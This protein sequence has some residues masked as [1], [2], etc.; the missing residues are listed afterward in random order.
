MPDHRTFQ[1]LQR[2]HRETRSFH[3][4]KYDAGR[5]RAVRSSNLEENILNIVADRPESSTRA[6]AHHLS[7]SHQ[8]VCR[9]LN[10]NRLHL[11]HFQRLQALNPTDYF[12]R[13]P[14]GGTSMCA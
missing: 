14:V 2:Q 13:L 10:E 6:V 12:L 4:N 9:V 1:W 7:V 11:F 8:T 3:V 5:R